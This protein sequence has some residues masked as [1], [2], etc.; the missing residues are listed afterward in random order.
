[1]TE[2]KAVSELRELDWDSIPSSSGV[3]WWYFPQQEIK[4][5]GVAELCNLDQLHL[6]RA[7]DGK[8]CLYHG[9]AKNLS[10]RIEWHAAQSLTLKHLQSGFLST[11]RFSLLALNNFDYFREEEEINKYFDKLAVGWQLAETRDEA[12][13]M[14]DHEL[15]GEYH[16]PLNI[17]GNRRP[18]LIQY[19]RYLKSTRS[20][21]KRRFLDSLEKYHVLK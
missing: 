16:Y 1:M 21:Y 10:Q 20:A 7:S 3:Y 2:P 4:A 15:C 17:Q 5:L 9:M 14:E 6:R 11:F 8:V 13:S 12:K 19:I 18:E